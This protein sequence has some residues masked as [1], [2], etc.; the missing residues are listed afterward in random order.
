MLQL[1]M[2]GVY[3]EPT[4]YTRI[5]SINNAP[6]LESKQHKMYV[7]SKDMACILKQL[8]TEPV[9]G[10]KGTATY[11]KIPGHDVAAKTGTTNENYDRWLC[12]FTKY[13]TAV[14]WYGFDKNESINFD[15]KNPA[16]L[17]WAD[18][19]RSIHSNLPNSKFEITNGV[20]TKTIC[21]DS[22]MIANSDCKNTYTEYFL[23]N[24]EPNEVCS[25][26]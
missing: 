11:C 12:G 15:G 21:K 19:M 13:Y 5:T 17:I 7:T 1:L 16:G 9:N 6:I 20:I 8:L 14:C 26:H 24:T 10:A 18:V 3:R 22:G 2:I 23:K 25:I 4:F